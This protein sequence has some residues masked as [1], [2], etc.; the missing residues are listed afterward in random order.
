MFENALDS[1]E[2][3]RTNSVDLIFLDIQNEELSGIQLLNALKT[4]PYVIFTT[5]YDSYALQG[6][7]LTS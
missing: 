4:R 6:F 3:I 2:Y 7:D 1:I 5:A